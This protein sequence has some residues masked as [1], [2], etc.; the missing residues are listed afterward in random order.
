MIRMSLSGQRFRNAIGIAV[1]PFRQAFSTSPI[2][3]ALSSSVG[4]NDH[5]NSAHKR[6]TLTLYRE[7]LRWC[8]GT[9][10]D[11]PLSQSVPPIHLSPPQINSSGL[12]NLVAA[13]GGGGNGSF[14]FSPQ[15]C[16]LKETGI[17]VHSVPTSVEAKEIVRTVFRINAPTTNEVDQK[18]QLSLAFEWIKGLNE[19][20]KRLKEMK[21][22]RTKHENREGVKF[23]I[24]QVVKHKTVGWRGVILGWNRTSEKSSNATSLTQKSYESIGSEGGHDDNGIAY[25]VALD[26]GDAALLHSA[27]HSAALK[28]VYESD[29]TLVDDLDLMRVRGATDQLQRFDPESRSFVPGD[30]LAYEYPNDKPKEE[31][32][33]CCWSSFQNPSDESAK[34]IIQGTQYLAEYLRQIILGYTSAPEARKL[35]LL[36]L[37][38]DRLTKLANGDVVPNEDQFRL[39]QN[40]DNSGSSSNNKSEHQDSV[41]T[42]TLMKWQLQ[43]FMELTVELEDVLWARRK[44]L[45]TD[46]TNKF[47]LGEV[48]H[49]KKYGFR[50]VIV[51]WDPEPAYG[52]THWDGLQHIKNPEQY[53]FYHVIPDRND[54]MVAFGGE[55][56]WRYVCEENLELCPKENRDLDIDLEP[57]WTTDVKNAKYVPSDEL[58]LRHGEKLEDDGLTAKCLGE[59]KNIINYVYS[60]IREGTYAGNEGIEMDVD[61]RAIVDRIS[62]EHLFQ[63][64]KHAENSDTAAV[65]SDAFKEIWKGHKDR[66]IRYKFDTGVNYL[67]TGKTEEA[68]AVFSEVVDEDPM[69]AEAWNKAATCEFMI[70]NLD[71]SMAAAQK[72]L[73]IVPD[74]FQALNGLGLVYN[75]KKDLIHARDNFRKSIELDPWSP[76]APRLSVCLDTL[77]RWK[78]TS[79]VNVEKNTGTPEWKNPITSE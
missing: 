47:S 68:L 19:L 33:D 55:R 75:E 73:E 13:L 43:K 65:L 6:I 69:F 54:V 42:Q 71:A 58:R 1:P 38:L 9:D 51:A 76:V 48:V 34:N 74:H 78:N 59:I 39:I 10:K 66:D 21:I 45:E 3:A 23:R 8:D 32:E 49:H 79:V 27:K 64:L 72:T 4:N 57:E 44:T 15:T 77:K 31:K 17:T 63:I 37:Y 16:L 62:M 14:F 2:A 40:S 70:G 28:N 52:V 12:K 26:W 11:I 30:V 60:S 35:G 36:S 56:P 41:T 20:T 61:V 24:G 46:R 50:G 18:V 22:K 29:L 7:I 5:P 67:L 53:P 25:D